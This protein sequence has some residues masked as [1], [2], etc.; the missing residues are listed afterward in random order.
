M[1]FRSASSLTEKES[2]KYKLVELFIPDL[3][4]SI[5]FLIS[6][7]GKFVKPLYSKTNERIINKYLELRDTKE[8][9]VFAIW[10]PICEK[11]GIRD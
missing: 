1:T 5:R 3:E 11:I 9:C 10:R 6:R 4:F 7:V 2:L 8:K